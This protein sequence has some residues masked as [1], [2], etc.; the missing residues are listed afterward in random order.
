MNQVQKRSCS[1]AFS[2]HPWLWKAR[3]C[4]ISGSL[5]F[6]LG[7]PKTPHVTSL[8]F[9]PTFGAAFRPSSPVA[10]GHEQQHRRKKINCKALKKVSVL[11]KTRPFQ[12]TAGFVIPAILQGQGPVCRCRGAASTVSRAGESTR[13]P[14][15]SPETLALPC[16]ARGAQ[17]AS[18]LAG[19]LRE[20]GGQWGPHPHTSPCA[21]VWPTASAY[22]FVASEKSKP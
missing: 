19:F 10:Q 15:I 2:C 22:G 8:F 6:F 5:F 11:T 21:P 16:P 1:P 14:L 9:F 3:S 20:T 4:R 18:S 13:T 17:L 12:N 7:A